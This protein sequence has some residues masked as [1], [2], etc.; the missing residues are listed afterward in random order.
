MDIKAEE[1]IIKIINF[2]S[3]ILRFYGSFFVLD[4]YVLLHIASKTASTSP[5]EHSTMRTGG[6]TA[7]PHR[8]L[9]WAEIKTFD[10]KCEAVCLLS[11]NG[12]IV[13]KYCAQKHMTS[14]VQGSG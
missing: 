1:M 10:L 2:C 4:L 14:P 3:L 13:C 8:F 6:Q 5:A 7:V 9:S 12:A 11:V